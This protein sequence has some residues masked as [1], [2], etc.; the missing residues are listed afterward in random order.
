MSEVKVGHWC[1]YCGRWIAGGQVHL[2]VH[3]Q[4]CEDILCE[5]IRKDKY[6]GD[7]HATK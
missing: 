7:D 3:V 4:S 5:K 2:M 6:K 1:G